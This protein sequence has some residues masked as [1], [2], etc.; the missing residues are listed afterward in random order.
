MKHN[1]SPIIAQLVHI[2]RTWKRSN[3]I[4]PQCLIY[5][6]IQYM[7]NYVGKVSVKRYDF[8]YTLKVIVKI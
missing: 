3:I 8:I 6:S 4:S 7:N 5:G 1:S 2:I